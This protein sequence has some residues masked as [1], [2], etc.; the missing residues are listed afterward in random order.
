MA[1]TAVDVTRLDP[2]DIV[3]IDFDSDELRENWFELAAAWARRPPF[4]VIDRG[5]PNAVVSRNSEVREVLLSPERFTPLPPK[6]VGARFDP[7]FGLP[8]FAKRD[9]ASHDRLRRLT[10][11]WFGSGAAAR[12]EGSIGRHVNEVMDELEA[13]GDP[14]DLVADF[15]SKLM[16]RVMLEEMFG[17][18]EER[19]AIFLVMRGH[20]DHSVA[21]GEYTPEYVENFNRMRAV[22]DEIIEERERQPNPTDFIGAMVAGRRESG[23]QVSDD[24]IAGPVFAVAAGGIGTTIIATTHLIRLWMRHREEFEVLRTEP[25]LLPQAVEEATRLQPTSLFVM[26]RFVVEDTVIGGTRLY[27][28]MPLHVGVAAANLDP[29]VYPDPLRFDIR[30]KPKHVLTFGAG[31]HYCMGAILAKKTLMAALQAFME[32]HPNADVVDPTAKLQYEHGQIGELGV[33]ELPINLN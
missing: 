3:D 15:A 29:D 21:T 8:T 26:P 11:P 6:S 7:F 31:P 33:K 20:L 17:F 4:Y 23:E 27:Q 10:M 16:P 19:R 22:I 9:G 30:R 13:K 2:D 28:G 5:V 18:D 1:L 12:V 24:E 14:V 25:E 32:R